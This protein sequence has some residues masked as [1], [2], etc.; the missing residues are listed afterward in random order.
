MA[1]SVERKRHVYV[2]CVENLHGYRGCQLKV[3]LG[4]DPEL[5]DRMASEGLMRGMRVS[6]E[7]GSG[8]RFYRTH[9]V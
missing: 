1:S 8:I 6:V 2:K 5:A 3:L 4:V 7:D 9:L